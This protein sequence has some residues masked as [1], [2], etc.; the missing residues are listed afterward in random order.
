MSGDD[1]TFAESRERFEEWR[2]RQRPGREDLFI[3][4]GAHAAAEMMVEDLEQL[5]RASLVAVREFVTHLHLLL[6]WMAPED[7]PAEETAAD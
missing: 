4:A 3:R 7:K 6:T 1:R 5:D 2:R